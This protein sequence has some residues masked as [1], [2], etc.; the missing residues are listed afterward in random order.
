MAGRAQGPSPTDSLDTSIPVSLWVAAVLVVVLLLPSLGTAQEPTGQKSGEAFKF[1]VTSN[2]VVLNVGVRDRGG[3]T[4]EDL[5][6]EDFEITEDGK[7][8]QVSVFEFQRLEGDDLFLLKPTPDP[9]SAEPE[10][11]VARTRDITP[12]APG[13]VRYDDKRLL[14]LYF[15]FSSM[16][17]A[18]QIRA[19][20]AALKFLDEH[21]TTADLVAVMAFSSSLQVLQDFTDNRQLLREV[22]SSFR[23]GEASELSEL[24]ETSEEEAV[25]DGS[26]FVADE[27]EFNIFNTDLKLSALE[28][29]AK[30]LSS[31]PEKKALIYFSSGVGKTGTEN[32]SQL[33]SAV[34][35][36][37]R[38]NVAFYPIDARGLVAE[39]PLGDATQGSQRGTRAYSGAGQR[40]RRQRFNDQQD[41]LFTLAADTGG[42]ALLNS[43]DLSVG[44][45]RAQQDIS[46]YYIL[47]YYST[48]SKM[49]GRFRRVKI[50]VPSRKNLKLDYRS[51]YFGPK[52]FRRFSSADRERQL[53]EALLLGDPITDLTLALEVN[54]FRLERDRYFVPVAVKIPGSEFDLAR[55]RGHEQTRIDFIGQVRDSRR[56]LMANLRDHVQVKLHGDDAEQL[57]GRRLQY[58]TGFTLPPGRYTLKFLTRE[59]ESG[60]I[61]T[62]ETEFTIPDIDDQKDYARLSS[63]VWSNQREPLDSAIGVAERNKKL[64]ALHP[65]VRD[66]QKL[67]PSITRVFKNDQSLYVYFEVYDPG[68]QGDEKAP[69]VAASVSFFRDGKKAFE[70]EPLRVPALAPE[71][72][73][74]VPVEFQ[75]PL[76]ELSP[77]EYVCQVSAVDEFGQKFAFRRAP[78]VVLP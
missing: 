73:R 66:G 64:L 24:A 9:P 59:N 43:N 13:Q 56:K 41:T 23:A 54:Y 5:T 69:S 50:R 70:S 33:R 52:E 48:N 67:I 39:A 77:G 22:I 47:G 58:D 12:S 31:L 30:M 53:E 68:T 72:R 29:A 32:H 75:V 28:S 74:T 19:Q 42:K 55:K 45:V 78:L 15:D 17:P 7:R 18:D 63:V 46:S 60:K 34:N 14:V 44:M 62:F 26:A 61:G 36:A 16:A 37:V 8:Q 71:R 51:G 20:R 11:D 57:A 10:A 4:V 65:L 21:M 49:D 40:Q 27:S 25:D 3:N 35:A 76:S 6:A 1:E 2:L 38:A